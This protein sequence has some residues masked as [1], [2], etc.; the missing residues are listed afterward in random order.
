M[1]NRNYIA[2]SRVLLTW[3]L[4]LWIGLSAPAQVMAAGVLYSFNAGQASAYHAAT[5]QL[6]NGFGAVPASENSG[7]AYGAMVSVVPPPAAVWLF[8]SAL[9]LMGWLRRKTT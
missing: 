9:A 2:A 1:K 8:G 3:V 4:A 6:I 5:G 7:L